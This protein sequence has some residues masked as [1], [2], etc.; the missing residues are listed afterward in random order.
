MFLFFIL[1][2]L[3]NTTS[4]TA[5]FMDDLYKVC[6]TSVT[7]YA[8]GLTQDQKEVS[9]V[10]ENELKEMGLSNNLI[11]ASIVNAYAESRLNPYAVGDNGSSIGIFQ[12]NKNGLGH[13]ITTKKRHNIYVN[14]NV[15]G[16]QILKNK[17]LIDL[18]KNKASIPTL[19]AYISEFIMRPKEVEYNKQK[20]MKIA[21]DMFPETL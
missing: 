13:K 10:I 1:G 2:C 3:Q 8:V 19:S 17:T 20:R 18:D 9:Y 14:A 5:E 6:R 15:I 4:D 16:I 21:Q 11:A 7:D 12:L